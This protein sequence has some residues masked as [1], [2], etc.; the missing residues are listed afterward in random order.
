MVQS[1]LALFEK[2]IDGSRNKNLSSLRVPPSLAWIGGWTDLA[3]FFPA[4]LDKI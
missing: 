2:E 1:V 4:A 3:F